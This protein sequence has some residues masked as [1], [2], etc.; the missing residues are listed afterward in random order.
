MQLK[1]CTGRQLAL[2]QVDQLQLAGTSQHN[3][4]IWALTELLELIQLPLLLLTG[5][6]EVD[7]LIQQATAVGQQGLRG[8]GQ[9]VFRLLA[10]TTDPPQP[11]GRGGQQTKEL[12]PPWRRS[13][14]T[15]PPPS[16]AEPIKGWLEPRF[17]GKR[18]DRHEMALTAPV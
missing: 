9:T 13:P 15:R 10:A 17:G 18:G 6:L 5:Q 14:S 11:S 8:L 4:A 1:R 12:A 3:V 16:K 2:Q 7:E